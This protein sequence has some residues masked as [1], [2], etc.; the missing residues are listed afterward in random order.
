[1]AKP[2]PNLPEVGDRCR[3]RADKTITGI[4][5]KY[6]PESNWSRVKWDEHVIAPKLVHRFELMKLEE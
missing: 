6:Q 2:P 3:M 4:L 5:M 1:M